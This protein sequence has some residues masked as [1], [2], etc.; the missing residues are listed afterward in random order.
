[1]MSQNS[2]PV[3][4]WPGQTRFG[5]PK[6]ATTGTPSNAARCIVPVSL[7]SSKLHRLNSSIS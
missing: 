2:M 4:K 7:V 1:M 3:A 6:T 5:E